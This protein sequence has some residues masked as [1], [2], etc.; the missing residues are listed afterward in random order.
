MNDCSVRWKR[1]FAVGRVARRGRE[2]PTGAVGV[3]LDP[4]L[5]AQLGWKVGDMVSVRA[6]PDGTVTLQLVQTL[7]GTHG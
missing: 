4:D 5:T 6:S 7:R 3:V 1:L 2:R